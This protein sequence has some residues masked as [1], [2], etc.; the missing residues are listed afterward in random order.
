[1]KT[2]IV[3]IISL[4]CLFTYQL[5]GQSNASI[6]PPSTAIKPILEE[7]K[8]EA[9]NYHIQL[10]KKSLYIS[11]DS[12][13]YHFNQ[14]I[15][16]SK[17]INNKEIEARA[18]LRI[19]EVLLRK[20]KYKES[21][22]FLDKGLHFSEELD[23]AKLISE[24][25]RH[26]GNFN[27][28]LS[29]L[30]EALASYTISKKYAEASEDP[31]LI[32]LTLN[33]FGLLYINLKQY[34]KA[35]G[36]LENALA[37]VKQANFEHGELLITNNIAWAYLGKENFQSALDILEEKVVDGKFSR[38]KTLNLWALTKYAKALIET[39]DVGKGFQ[40]MV[41]AKEKASQLKL[42]SAV[43]E[44]TYVLASY[45]LDFDLI[46]QAIEIVLEGIN[47]SIENKKV[48]YLPTLY[49]QLADAYEKQGKY[50]MSL[51]AIKKSKQAQEELMQR[52][53]SKEV[54]GLEMQ[55]KIQQKEAEN[56]LLQLKNTNQKTF[57]GLLITSFL[58][59]SS[60]LYYY[61]LSLQR[62]QINSFKE[63]I[64]ADLH[65]DVTGNL[66]AISRIA[67]GLKDKNNSSE[68]NW[69]IDQ[70]VKKSNES[71]KNVIDVI[72]SL[73]ED[74]TQLGHLVEKIEDQ[75][76]LVRIN[77]KD[78]K[79]E[80]NKTNLEE[81]I[82]LSMNV[83]HH[84]LMIM[85]ESITNIQKHTESNLV[86]IDMK[87]VGKKLDISIYNEFDKLIENGFSSGRGIENIKRRVKELN[88]M[89]NFTK[90]SDSF[91]VKIVVRI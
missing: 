41:K 14:A 6:L 29:N 28:D 50:K 33:S 75:L 65:D 62:K 53:K 44:I 39:G 40:I 11:I 77:G 48:K 46:D 17:E 31:K 71:V 67:K 66:S 54:L 21:K 37:S 4:F 42:H 64:S 68:V 45:Y 90:K 80:L 52:E 43:D 86:K 19:G 27:W 34:D 7:S 38:D 76:D 88:G 49:G 5:N 15:Q 82:I 72:W 8:I 78:L 89:V 22:K 23:D 25:H 47:L 51:F 16:I 3:Y 74:E 1:M 30:K 60:F 79:V 18:N 63:R 32:G 58:L 59:F 61:F 69:K 85:K 70:L 91:L 55:Y 57:I 87:K 2:I 13:I 10:I 36:Y 84:L 12:S 81:H 26:I 9:A 24:A 20:Q 73:N 35:L 83:R 56:E